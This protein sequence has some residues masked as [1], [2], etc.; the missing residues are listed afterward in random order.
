M[1]GSR[2]GLTLIEMFI[3]LALLSIIILIAYPSVKGIRHE[4]MLTRAQSDLRLLQIAI[5]S[6]YKNYGRYPH[7]DNYMSE[8]LVA[9]PCLLTRSVYDPF[10]QEAN[11]PYVYVISAP[12]P[13]DADY[14]VIYS[15]ASGGGFGGYGCN[16]CASVDQV[17]TVTLSNEVVSWRSNGF[18]P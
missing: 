5:E 13:A 15:V 17:G 18:L 8:L 9:K 10:A 2:P 16:G 3:V 1:K 6:Y 7:C 4:A 12:D 11:T 14:Y